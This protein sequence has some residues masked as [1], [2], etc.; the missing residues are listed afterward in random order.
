MRSL[1]TV[2]MFLCLTVMA[3]GQRIPPMP[4][5][6]SPPNSAEDFKKLPKDL[7]EAMKKGTKVET[8]DFN[9]VTV[10][11]K[12]GLVTVEGTTSTPRKV[13]I[14]PHLH[15]GDK[16]DF[17]IYEVVAER[18]DRPVAQ[19]IT[20]YRATLKMHWQGKRGIEIFGGFSIRNK[21]HPKSVRIQVK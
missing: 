7:Q 10:D 16:P 3:Y 1:L 19:Q 18:I 5:T 8:V 14:V 6:Q 9:L 15:V 11:S 17:W 20:P 2:V 21:V 13:F 12:R 4:H